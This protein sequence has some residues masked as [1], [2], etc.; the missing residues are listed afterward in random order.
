MST[1]S[2][3]KGT[4]AK[5]RCD[6][7][8]KRD[9]TLSQFQYDVSTLGHKCFVAGT[10]VGIYEMIKNNTTS[11][12]C[13]YESW[14]KENNMKF[15][16]DY[17][18]KLEDEEDSLNYKNDDYFIK[19]KDGRQPYV[20]IAKLIDFFKKKLEN[21]GGLNI[22]PYVL[23]A[24]YEKKFSLHIIFDGVCFENTNQL[25]LFFMNIVKENKYIYDLVEKGIVDKRVYKP[26]CLRLPMCTKYGQGRPLALLRNFDKEVIERSAEKDITFEE[27]IS[28]CAT[29]VETC[30]SIKEIP[31]NSGKFI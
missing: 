11:E 31:K 10:F 26:G 20:E 18:L 16:I 3:F 19:L 28:C 8:M 5:K 14:N 1:T 23:D 15:F 27:F 29:H 25:K 9:A 30:M 22:V 13:Y 12:S 17:D 24:S 2:I 6:D 21:L 7:F 4:G